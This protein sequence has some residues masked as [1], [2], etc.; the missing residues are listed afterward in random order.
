MSK[1]NPVAH[2]EMPAEDKKRM[3]E[4][5]SKVF[6]WQ[7]KMLGPDMGEYVV[8]MTA[9]SVDGKMGPPKMPGSI[10]GGFYQ[11]GDDEWTRQPS[12]V[13]SVDDLKESI[14]KIK[15]AGGRLKGDPVQIPGVGWYVSFVDTEG[16]HLSAMQPDQK[17]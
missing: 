11:K 12:F 2:F 13:I 16:N 14:E 10:N 4:F 9:E 8:V 7:T 17:M 3:S 5:Y 1:M 6:G 15:A